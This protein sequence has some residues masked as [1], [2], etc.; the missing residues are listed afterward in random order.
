[1]ST[2]AATV[3]ISVPDETAVPVP[4]PVALSLAAVART[5]V[6]AGAT[7]CA[8]RIRRAGVEAFRR[9]FGDLQG[10]RAASVAER[11][12]VRTEVA[13]FAGRA[14]IACGVAVDVD[15]VVASG[16]R[17]GK[18]LRDAYPQ[19]ADTFQAQACSLG[20]CDREIGRMWAWLAKICVVTGTSPQGLGGVTKVTDVVW[21][22]RVG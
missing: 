8:R 3:H 13:S 12:Q 7:P 22:C 2:P 18:Y 20:F 19:Q 5:Y 17:W 21:A 4:V 9:R 6:Q 14:V 1:M 11:R 15:F 16:C 10:W